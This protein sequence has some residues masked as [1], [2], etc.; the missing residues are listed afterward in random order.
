MLKTGEHAAVVTAAAAVTALTTLARGA[1][2]A[3]QKRDR[4]ISVTGPPLAP[5]AALYDCGCSSMIDWGLCIELSLE[6]GQVR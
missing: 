4:S 5:Q 2:S 6:S 1:R 3:L